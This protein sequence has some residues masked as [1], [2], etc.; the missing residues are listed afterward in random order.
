MKFRP[1]LWRDPEAVLGS[2]HNS[3]LNLNP[4]PVR[5]KAHVVSKPHFLPTDTQNLSN[6]IVN[7]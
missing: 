1:E 4:S 2:R 7:T 5:T 6:C 3:G